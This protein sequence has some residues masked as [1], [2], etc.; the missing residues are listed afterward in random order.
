MKKF[1]TSQILAVA[2]S[3]FAAGVIVSLLSSPS[4]GTQN[5]EWISRST[6]D[7]KSKVKES[8]KE[9]RNKNFPDLYEATEHIGLTDDDLMN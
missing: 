8:G 3:S 1:S 2:I 6:S 7:L 9:L 5:R 4:S